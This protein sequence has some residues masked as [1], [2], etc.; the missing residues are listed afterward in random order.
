MNLQVPLVQDISHHAR[1]RNVNA[2]IRLISESG[3]GYDFFC[4][5]YP[6]H[7]HVVGKVRPHIG[8]RALLKWP[9]LS[10]VRD[11]PC[12]PDARLD[13][14]E[15]ILSLRTPPLYQLSPVSR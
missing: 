4:E 1:C 11:N 7:Y 5:R 14:L 15:G 6:Y 10:I 12:N 3:L 9:L 2:P 13:F 8:T